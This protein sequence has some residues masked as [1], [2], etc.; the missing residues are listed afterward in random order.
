[1]TRGMPSEETAKLILIQTPSTWFAVEAV[2]RFSDLGMTLQ[3]NAQAQTL[4]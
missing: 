4:I 3:G 2:C 1:M